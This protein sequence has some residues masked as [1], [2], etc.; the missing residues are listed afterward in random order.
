MS[1]PG[2]FAPIPLSRRHA[3]AGA[4]LAVAIGWLLVVASVQ[5]QLPPAGAALVSRP[6]P[7]NPGPV[8]Q[9]LNVSVDGREIDRAEVEHDIILT[10]TVQDSKTAVSRLVF[11]WSVPVGEIRGEGPRVAWH[12]P[13]GTPTPVSGAA[14]LELV[15]QYPDFE[16]GFLPAMKEHRSSAEGPTMYVN[17]SVA[18]ITKMSIRFLVELFGD[19]SV[20]P[21][22]CLVDFSDTCKGKEEELNDIRQTRIEQ[23]VRKAE[24]H[25]SKIEFRSSMNWAEIAAPCWFHETDKANGRFHYSD[26]TC[27]LTAVYDR[28]RWYL[29]D[30][31]IDPGIHGYE[32]DLRAQGVVIKP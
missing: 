7:D 20:S 11:N 31:H 4:F 14:M 28:P 16:S 23:V 19:S 3:I 21:E 25:V 13:K 1:A 18:E 30:S 2:S 22:A 10:A 24:A 6:R 27:R 8:I 32:D 5:A 15:E 26:S 29:C 9:A 12:V 17:D